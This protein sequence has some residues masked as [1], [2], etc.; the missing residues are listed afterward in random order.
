MKHG[1]IPNIL[2]L[3]DMDVCSLLISAIIHDFKHP[4]VTNLFLVNSGHPIA[5]KYN[6]NFD[7]KF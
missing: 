3:N 7:S 2:K 6:G 4:G 1:N 5:I